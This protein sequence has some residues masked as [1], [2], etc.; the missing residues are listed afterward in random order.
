MTHEK[1]KSVERALLGLA[2]EVGKFD[3]DGVTV[4]F[5]ND[6]TILDNTKVQ[7]NLRSTSQLIFRLSVSR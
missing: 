3:G 2:A 4:R 1:W 6:P 5:L 7:S